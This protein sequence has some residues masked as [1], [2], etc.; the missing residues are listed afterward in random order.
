MDNSH[1][2]AIQYT[3]TPENYSDWIT[4]RSLLDGAVLNTGVER[5]RQ[6][7]SKHLEL[8]ALGSFAHNGVYLSVATNQ[9]RIEIAEASKLRLFVGEKE[10]IPYFK[11]VTKNKAAMGEEFKFYARQGV[12]YVIEKTV[13]IYTSKDIGVS[14]P[15]MEAIDSLKKAPRFGGLLYN[16][17]KKWKELLKSN[18]VQMK[19]S[20]NF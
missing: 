7:N 2:A 20:K 10:K 12:S 3:I 14:D 17:E 16:H 6:L 15:I 8:L 5:Y 19:Y 1:Y 11:L 18:G 13:S 9:S 4:V